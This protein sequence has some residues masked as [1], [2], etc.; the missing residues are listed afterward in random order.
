MKQALRFASDRFAHDRA[1]AFVARRCDP[2]AAPGTRG[3]DPIDAQVARHGRV[4][5]T[6]Q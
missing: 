4:T 2:G 6:L 3:R 5:D 1:G